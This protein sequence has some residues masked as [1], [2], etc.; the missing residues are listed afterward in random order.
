MSFDYIVTC[1]CK[2]TKLN[3]LFPFELS[4]NNT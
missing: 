1:E 3:K 4:I 2:N